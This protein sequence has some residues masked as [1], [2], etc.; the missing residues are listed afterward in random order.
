MLDERFHQVS[1]DHSLVQELVNA[2]QLAPELAAQ[3]PQRN[4]LTQALGITAAEQLHIGVARGARSPGT[5]F[6]L[7]TDGLTEGLDDRAL[8]RLVQ[9]TDLAAQECV[10]QLLLDALDG[11]GSDNITTILVRLS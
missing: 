2:G 8:G 9:R 1:H 11:S 6:L 7:C 4:V 3:H 10:D 5:G